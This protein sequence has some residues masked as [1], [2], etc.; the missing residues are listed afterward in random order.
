MLFQFACAS[1][2]LLLLLLLGMVVLGVD[3]SLLE[4]IVV[5]WALLTDDLVHVA[6]S[7]VYYRGLW[8][9]I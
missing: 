8:D 7:A 9:T 2:L 3:D 6:C 4:R 1:N 5:L